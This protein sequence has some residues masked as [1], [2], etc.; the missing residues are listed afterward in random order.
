M[1]GTN[2]KLSNVLAAIGLSQM[3]RI[4]ELLKKRIELAENYIGLLSGIDGI[5]LPDKVKD[6]KHSYQSFC[7]FIKKRDEILKKMRD[8]GTEVQI[9][10]YSLH[11][12]LAF[13]NKQISRLEGPFL[14]S[15]YVFDHCLALPLY[16]TLSFDQQI[17]IKDQLISLL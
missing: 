16:H 2:Y 6:C 14:S 10:T 4:D 5:E 13:Q 3:E 17:L 15:D 12:H 11:K 9:G 1:I 8:T 7:I